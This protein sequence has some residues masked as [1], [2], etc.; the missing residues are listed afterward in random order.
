MKIIDRLKRALQ[1][2]KGIKEPVPTPEQMEVIKAYG[3]KIRFEPLCF[4]LRCPFREEARKEADSHKT[5]RG[6]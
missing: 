3:L 4:R 1:R 6:T 5:S 2:L